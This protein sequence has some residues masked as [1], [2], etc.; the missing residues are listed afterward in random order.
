MTPL[1]I[2]L[3]VGFILFR[4]L[5]FVVPWFADWQHA[6]RAALGLMFLLTASAHWGKRRPYLVRMVPRN[7]GHAEFFVTLTGF[8]EIAIAIGLQIPRLAAWIALA[9]IAMLCALFP[10][11]VKAAREHLILLHRPVPQVGPRLLTQLVFVASLAASV[12][13]R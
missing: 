11:N 12:C 7:I 3:I 5:G 4:A 10:A 8:A 2:A 6:L 1:F 13:P 9:A